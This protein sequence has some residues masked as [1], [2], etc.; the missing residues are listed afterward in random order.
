MNYTQQIKEFINSDLEIDEW[1]ENIPLQ[2]QPG[3]LRAFKDYSL[4]LALQNGNY[5]LVAELQ[6]MDTKTDAYEDAIITELAAKAEYDKALE[7]RDK[8]FAEMEERVI[9]IRNYVIE[10]IVN[11]EDNAEAMLELAKKIIQLEKDNGNHELENWKAIA[12]LL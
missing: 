5:E 9:G 12:H 6:K 11:Q 1:I 4:N 8:V 2:E 10:C 7:E 3:F